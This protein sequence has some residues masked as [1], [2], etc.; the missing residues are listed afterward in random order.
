MSCDVEVE[1]LAPIVGAFSAPSSP[2]ASSSSSEP[3]SPKP[4][5]PHKPP[6]PPKQ[7]SPEEIIEKVKS[8]LEGQKDAVEKFYQA[9]Q[10]IEDET[11]P[12][13]LRGEAL[14]AA[15]NRITKIAVQAR[16]FCE[17]MMDNLSLLDNLDE[18]TH[19]WQPQSGPDG[20]VISLECPEEVKAQRKA[21]AKQS[22]EKLNKCE[23]KE[24]AVLKAL[25]SLTDNQE[26]KLGAS[27]EA[28]A[29]TGQKKTAFNEFN[30]DSNPID[31]GDITGDEKELDLPEKEA[32]YVYKDGIYVH[33]SRVFSDDENF[34]NARVVVTDPN[35]DE[36]PLERDE[37]DEDWDEDDYYDEDAEE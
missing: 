26:K 2:A 33:D 11:F 32:R 7:L 12:K 36:E 27:D 35:D 28:S 10:G 16:H 17:D 22:Q 9:V 5:L 24:Q 4:K 13:D 30:P 37:D 34:E 14:R 21:L 3:P 20:G 19:G 15:H 25:K 8:R 23:E 31:D 6:E 18:T 29:E 1:C